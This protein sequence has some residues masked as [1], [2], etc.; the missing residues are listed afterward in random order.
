MSKSL[1]QPSSSSEEPVN[2]V[3]EKAQSEAN[4]IRET[5]IREAYDATVAQKDREQSIRFLLGLP[6]TGPIP[7]DVETQLEQLLD[8]WTLDQKDSQAL[9]EDQLRQLLKIEPGG[10]ISEDLIPSVEEI[11]TALDKHIPPTER[12]SDLVIAMPEE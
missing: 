1:N 3:P 5:P 7:A 10:P 4:H 11:R 2:E 8:R 12:L 6:D 9:L